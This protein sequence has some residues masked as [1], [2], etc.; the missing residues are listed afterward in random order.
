MVIIRQLN[1]QPFDSEVFLFTTFCMDGHRSNFTPLNNRL[2][3][4]VRLLI[5]M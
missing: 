5:Y 1:R 4:A 2:T 3:S